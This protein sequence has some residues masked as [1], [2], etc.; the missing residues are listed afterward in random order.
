MRSGNCDCSR[1]A[2]MATSIIRM[3]KANI[4]DKKRSLSAPFAGDQ[5]PQRGVFRRGVALSPS[6]EQVSLYG[7]RGQ[8][9]GRHVPEH[10]A[11]GIIREERVAFAKA[12]EG[13]QVQHIRDLLL[14][15]VELNPSLPGRGADE[16]EQITGMQRRN[17]NEGVARQLCEGERPLAGQWMVRW[18]NRNELLTQNR[19]R[20]QAWLVDG[21]T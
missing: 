6:H 2:Q 9:G 17:F 4:Q 7:G 19:N 20:L 12:D 13:E 18:Q 1:E 11:F 14:D 10:Q 15:R 16:G 3:R 21:R 8:G 5:I